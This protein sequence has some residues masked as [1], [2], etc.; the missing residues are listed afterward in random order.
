MGEVWSSSP[1]KR[2]RKKLSCTSTVVCVTYT[3]R[4]SSN[5]RSKR[6]LFA[7]A[8]GSLVYSTVAAGSLRK[9]A[10]GARNLILRHAYSCH[11]GCSPTSI[12][13][14]FTNTLDL[15]ACQFVR[16]QHELLGIP[17]VRKGGHLLPSQTG[18][19]PHLAEVDARKVVDAGALPRRR[20]P[21]AADER[22]AV[23]VIQSQC[24]R[25]AARKFAKRRAKER[26][27][28]NKASHARQREFLL[29]QRKND[30]AV[31]LQRNARRR[32]SVKAVQRRRD[33][34][35]EARFFEPYSGPANAA[36][37]DDNPVSGFKNDLPPDSSR[38]EDRAT[39]KVQGTSRVYEGKPQA[40]Q[41]EA[42]VLEL[43]D[44]SLETQTTDLGGGQ[45]ERWE[46]HSSEAGKLQNS[47]RSYAAI[48]AIYYLQRGTEAE[49]LRRESIAAEE[50]ATEIKRKLNEAQMEEDESWESGSFE[51][52]RLQ[53]SARSYAAI[54]T[55]DYLRRA[56]ETESLRQASVVAG[57]K[58]AEVKRKPTESEM[59][60]E[61]YDAAS[62]IQRV[63]RS[64]Q[65]NDRVAVLRQKRDADTL[66]TRQ[67]E[68][69]QQIVAEQKAE[70]CIQ[71][72]E[73]SRCEVER[74]ATWRKQREIDV[75]RNL[76]VESVKR[77]VARQD[78]ASCIQRVGRSRQARLR[79][80]A[81]RRERDAEAEYRQKEAEMEAERHRAALGIQQITRSKQ[82]SDR[83]AALRQ[84]RDAD[85]LHT[86]QLELEL[87][88]I[89]QRE[90]A[91]CIQRLARVHSAV[92]R[93]AALRK[94]REIGTQR[95]LAVE[96]AKLT[97]LRENAASCIQR[98]GRSRQARL[99][100]MAARRERDIE[101]KCKQEEAEMEAER[102]RAALGI[103]RVARSKQASDRVAM[104]REKRDADILRAQKLE[105]EQEMIAQREAAECIQR[106]ARM[107]SAV[108]RAAALRKQREID[109][110]R[111]LAVESSKRTSTRED[112]VAC[113]QRMARSRQARLR[114]AAA[115]RERD[116][117]IKRKLQEAE[118]EAERHRAALGIQRVA[119]SKQ[120]ND[121]V[122]ALRQKR[123]EDILR[124]Q[125][126]ELEQEL[127]A[128]REA[129]ECIQR[130]ARRHS[131][132]ERVAALRQQRE[133]DIQ[134]DLAVELARREDAA[135][136]IQQVAR[137]RQA[138]RRVMVARRERNIEIKRKLQE[139]EMEAE[140]HH[141]ALVIQQMTRSKQ[142]SD[143]VAVLREKRNAD[144]LHTRQLELELEL[145]AQ[146]EAAECIQRLARMHS[147][148]ER[149]ASLRKQRKKDIQRALAVESAKKTAIRE[150]A[151]LCIQRAGRSRQAQLRVTAARRERDVEIKRRQEE[152]EREAKRHRAALGIQRVARSKQASDRVA[153]L[154]EKRDA[155]ILRTRQLELEQELVSQ[156]EAAECIQRLARIH[157]A[158]ERVASLRRQREID[159]QR[160]LAVESAKQTSTQ[161]EAAS[162]IQRVGRTRQARL[163]TTA[164][165]KHREIDT[166]REVEVAE[167]GR[168]TPSRDRET[169]SIERSVKSRQADQKRDDV[170]REH[171]EIDAQHSSSE[172]EITSQAS[173]SAA[174]SVSTSKTSE[175]VVEQKQEQD[176]KEKRGAEVDEEVGIGVREEGLQ[177]KDLG[178]QEVAAENE[179]ESI[180]S[181]FA[182]M[183][184][185]ARKKSIAGVGGG[186]TGLE[187]E[188][189]LSP[190]PEQH[191]EKTAG[192]TKLE[193]I[194]WSA[195]SNHRVGDA[196]NADKNGGERE[197]N[198]TWE[199]LGVP[200]S[201]RAFDSSTSAA[202]DADGNGLLGHGGGV[203]GVRQS[204]SSESSGWE[205]E[206]SGD[207]E[208]QQ[209]T[210]DV[211]PASD[212]D[213][214]GRTR[215]DRS[216][217]SGVVDQHGED[218]ENNVGVLVS[219]VE[220][221][222]PVAPGGGVNDEAVEFR[223]GGNLSVE[224]VEIAD[225]T[226]FPPTEVTT[227]EVAS[228][229][230]DNE[231]QWRDERSVN[232][233][234]NG[235]AATGDDAAE[236]KTHVAEPKRDDEEQDVTHRSG[237]DLPGS[238][239]KS[240]DHVSG[241][242]SA[243]EDVM[244]EWETHF[245]EETGRAYYYHTK[246]GV[247]SWDHPRGGTGEIE[248][249]TT[250]TTDEMAEAHP[251]DDVQGVSSA[252]AVAKSPVLVAA[253]TVTEIQPLEAE[254]ALGVDSGRHEAIPEQAQDES[255]A[256][257]EVH[258]QDVGDTVVGSE[259]D[260]ATL[261]K[262][263]SE[264]ATDVVES[265][266]PT[267]EKDRRLEE[268]VQSSS[269]VA[270]DGGGEA[271]K[272]DVQWEE[273]VDP[274]SGHKYF[275]NP[276]TR[277]S[278][279]ALPDGALAV[280]AANAAAAV[281]AA[282]A[283]AE[284]AATAEAG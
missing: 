96:S 232:S 189:A 269:A 274:D 250:Q 46:S 141:A 172:L 230:G 280:A 13:V 120:A 238:N 118:M 61:G 240:G 26:K 41:R 180:S 219:S 261:G 284:A 209:D 128:R 252:Q 43:R 22:D 279:W 3:R 55:V 216:A 27:A 249:T 236:R 85:I 81:A 246:S 277:Q 243:E 207:S 195:E 264:T 100:V 242:F 196:D 181:M 210:Q 202:A 40:A 222:S 106:L 132:V 31:T 268:V 152:A 138:W 136:C 278:T 74:A 11:V 119:R 68:L 201:R 75:Q 272:E 208:E 153:M 97:A 157:S 32:I 188:S 112:A 245:D 194:E 23:V 140:R 248:Q 171:R 144:I 283:A 267:K 127:I 30:A 114:V 2:F 76:A 156:R 87:E 38:R 257:G 102:H 66:Q 151:A 21:S 70:G 271:R 198:E 110:Q 234:S 231:P 10:S 130:L 69:E 139:A 190:L 34:R 82:A 212:A 145:V 45:S 220:G 235:F 150:N 169:V 239:E 254:W 88:L 126:L 79:V 223:E 64:K 50:V 203:E 29:K 173:D 25:R 73:I 125:K 93:V 77:T 176:T 281:A 204:S 9:F 177:Q 226:S 262:D 256:R 197:G 178:L 65:A 49:S 99:R 162:C 164:L 52:A 94:L 78:A 60:A 237:S 183:M 174:D 276:A 16:H 260:A 182:R 121:H 62:G 109:V 6:R 72:L 86:R 8:S 270:A 24:R 108:E 89:A 247:T 117:E 37:N 90:A 19:A 63:A 154:R 167:A 266:L 58:A 124:A 166:Q 56:S 95:D 67:L 265:F 33:E 131:A 59:E 211:L 129:A 170:I 186:Y 263:Q 273:I 193:A 275:Y 28:A 149:V 258:A 179:P 103:Q 122:A 213:R 47:A 20:C 83:V 165:R 135:A 143:C 168:E 5:T 133:I 224:S 175:S 116:I 244:E 255:D 214:G 163:R 146:R 18:K 241:Q 54:K 7:D 107:Y 84:K 191:A 229:I 42:N 200:D 192:N 57:E 91:E 35:E 184:D 253:A 259:V 147:A 225:V 15:Q 155:D 51:A 142:A 71:P 101:V 80:T 217:S 221:I 113:I 4:N 187:T 228:F 98:A 160:A 39:S 115:R 17:D 44:T 159:I 92:E 137:S 14:V 48:K 185:T 36:A 251:E 158:V 53:A 134:R 206:S 282:A 12:F 111:D 218:R 1:A 227:L 161:E 104:L 233:A 123:D 148:V 105:L 215:R 205:S 199:V